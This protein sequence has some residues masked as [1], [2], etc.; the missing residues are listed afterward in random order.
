MALDI[1]NERDR[2]CQEGPSRGEQLPTEVAS[3][4]R[5]SLSPSFLPQRRW[6]H[7]KHGSSGLSACEEA[8]ICKVDLKKELGKSESPRPWSVTPT[9]AGCQDGSGSRSHQSSRTRASKK[10]RRSAPKSSW[11]Q[12]VPALPGPGLGE[13]SQ[14]EPGRW[15]ALCSPSRAREDDPCA[16]AEGH[17]PGLPSGSLTVPPAQ[18]EAGGRP[19]KRLCLDRGQR[20]QTAQR[21][22]VA[23]GAVLPAS[24]APAEEARCPGPQAGGQPEQGNLTAGPQRKPGCCQA[25]VA[26]RHLCF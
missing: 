2:F 10:R 11:C 5:D 15:T 20:L 7:A 23:S 13:D 26:A 25:R 3:L 19:V 18:E 16:R 4:P 21:E 14:G 9:R 12:G 17:D 1:L 22:P 6:G 24:S 8:P